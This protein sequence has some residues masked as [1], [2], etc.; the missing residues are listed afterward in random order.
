M[1]RYIFF[2]AV[3]FALFVAILFAPELCR[4]E[5]L[6]DRAMARP[7]Y[8]HVIDQRRNARTLFVAGAGADIASSFAGI[9]T[10]GREALFGSSRAAPY[11]VA[12]LAALQYWAVERI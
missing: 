4:G 2:A 9:A 11:F 6:K 10:G 8:L 7:I 12:G 3:L 1:R 5:S